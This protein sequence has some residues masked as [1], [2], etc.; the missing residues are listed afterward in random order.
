MEAHNRMSA[1]EKPFAFDDL[2]RLGDRVKLARSPWTVFE[3]ML[4]VAIWVVWVFG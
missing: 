2:I 1:D 4:I 3:L